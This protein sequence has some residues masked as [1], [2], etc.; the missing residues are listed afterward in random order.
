MK[1]IKMTVKKVTKKD[2]ADEKTFGYVKVAKFDDVWKLA[3][4][5]QPNFYGGKD[6]NRLKAY[7]KEVKKQAADLEEAI[8]FIEKENKK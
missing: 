4:V 8:T 7:A 6:V 5:T 3:S 2:D 1:L